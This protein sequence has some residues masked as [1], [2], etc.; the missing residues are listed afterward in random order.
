MNPRVLV[1]SSVHPPDDPRI[2]EKLIRSIA[3]EFD[4][5]YAAKD[6][7]P[8][9]RSDHEWIPLVGSRSQRR[10]AVGSLLANDPYDI[11]VIHD[12]E[13]LPSAI[14]Q[15][16]RGR[17]I[18][19]DLHENVPA[20]VANRDSIPSPLRRPLSRLVRRY[21][22]YAEKKMPI[23]LAEDGYRSLFASGHSVF[24]NY[25]RVGDLPMPGGDRDGP[26]IY[27]GDITEVRG[28]KTLI[29]A[30][31]LMSDTRNVVAIGRYSA[32]FGRDLSHQADQ[33]N[34]DLELTGWL[35]HVEAMERVTRASIGVSPLTDTG[36]YRHSLPTK[37]LEYMALGVPVVASD[38]PGTRSVIARLSGV[39]LVR[40]GDAMALADALDRTLDSYESQRPD[41]T[42][43]R[44][45]FIWPDS[46]VL[47]FYRSLLP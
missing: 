30:V 27:V 18:V 20:Q 21:L 8:N 1:A 40:P 37:T 46:D 26:I 41:T 17:T 4:V 43:V 25:P 23:T 15:S 6:P 36:N 24:P 22:L 45:G 32:A 13:L 19:F 14:K 12:P 34:V 5:A 35:T 28:I 16:R 42:L 44:D 39:A 31:G 38:L 9:D 33:L 10:R 47:E 2:R 11:A 3:G 7:G 29:E